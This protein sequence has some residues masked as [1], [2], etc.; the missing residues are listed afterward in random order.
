MDANLLKGTLRI[1]GYSV[2]EMVKEMKKSG[3]E[4]SNS[5]FYKKL[6]E[7]SEFTASEITAI[8]EIAGLSKNE[9]YNIFFKELVS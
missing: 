8:T 1:K 9:M 5:S 3:V 7:E 4:I 2:S 6:R